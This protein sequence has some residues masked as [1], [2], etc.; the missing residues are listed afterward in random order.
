MFRNLSIGIK[1]LGGVALAIAGGLVASGLALSAIKQMNARVGAIHDDWLPAMK[2]A[3]DLRHDVN[4][5]RRYQIVVTLGDPQTRELRLPGLQKAQA[6]LAEHLKELEHYARDGDSRRHMA[7]FKAKWSLYDE[8]AQR[9]ESLMRARKI[10][11]GQDV[12]SKEGFDRFGPASTALEDLVDHF[13]DVT[14]AEVSTAQ[15]AAERSFYLVAL[16][17]GVVTLL[18]ATGGWLATRAVVKPIRSAVIA[19]E[20]VAAGNYDQSVEVRSN[21]E[22]GR[23]GTALNSTIGAVRSAVRSVQE[24]AAREREQGEVLAGKVDAMVKVLEAVAK[25]DASQRVTVRGTDAIGRLGE[26]LDL[27]LVDKADADAAI[28]AAAEREKKEAAELRHKVDAMVDVLESVAR[29]DASRRISVKGEDA[30]G[31]LGER[32][33][34]FLLEKAHAEQ[35]IAAANEREKRE[36]EELRRNVDLMVEVVKAAA[37]GDLTKSVAI[38]RDDAIG[39]MAKGLSGFLGDLRQSVSSIAHNAQALA[40]AAEELTSNSQQMGANADETAAQANVVSAASEQVSKNV[41]TVATGAEEMGAS[42]REIAKSANEAAKI[43]TAAVKVA[44]T[45]NATISKLGESSAEIGKVIKVITSIAEQTNLLALNA[46]IEAARAGEQG[47]GFAVVA[48]EVKE[49]AKETAR[50]TEDI[51]RKI[52]TIQAD[53]EGAVSAIAQIG[54]VINQI[55]DISS[56]IASAVEEQS[57]TTNEIGRNVAEA[58]KGSSEIAANITGVATAANSTRDGA[59]NTLQAS[60][61]LAKMASELQALVNQFQY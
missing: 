31:R 35:A 5:V 9:A 13:V 8:T 45:T 32:L 22:I 42:I 48:N 44:E 17:L 2:I 59:G 53:T 16:V 39:Q 3:G 50:A 18:S 6:Q 14:K 15:A 33:D 25:G 40:G 49:L 29:G 12:M 38:R 7:E 30:I 36:A 10:S 27:F 61:S 51:S 19:L 57:A 56:T 43:A 11:E 46:T 47:K 20:Q 4:V 21:D 28:F 34:R 60:A 54:H 52:E 37:A 1:L 58:A 26:R 23:M 55:N 24:A 41:Q